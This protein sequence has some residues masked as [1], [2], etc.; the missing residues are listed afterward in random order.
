MTEKNTVGCITDNITVGCKT[1]STIGVQAIVQSEYRHDRGNTYMHTIT[2]RV[3]VTV[4]NIPSLTEIRY[5][6]GKR[7]N[8]WSECNQGYP[9]KITTCLLRI[10]HYDGHF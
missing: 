6:D 7:Y 4:R 10:Y 8:S 2:I 9:I 3:S 1:N 5:F